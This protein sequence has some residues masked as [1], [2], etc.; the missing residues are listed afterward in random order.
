MGISAS[1]NVEQKTKSVIAQILTQAKHHP[2]K[3]ALI[4]ESLKEPP[5][6]VSY[7]QLAQKIFAYSDGLSE[8]VQK[9]D[10]VLLAFPSSIE[11]WLAFLAC[12]LLETIAVPIPL[13]T[14]KQ[15]LERYTSI[16]NDADA[17][18]LLTIDAYVETLQKNIATSE[19]SRPCE[20]LCIE[21][22]EV[23]HDNAY[24][25]SLFDENDIQRPSVIQYT[26]GSTSTPKGVIL[27]DNNILACAAGVSEI[28]DDGSL[29][30]D[31]KFLN[32]L[33]HYHDYGLMAIGLWPLI[34]G[35]TIVQVATFDIVRNCDKWYELISQY[36]INVTGITPSSF[37]FFKNNSINAG[38]NLSSL[39][40]LM[41]GAEVI[42]PTELAKFAEHLRRYQFES[43]SLTTGFGM[44]ET[45]VACTAC[46]SALNNTI[47]IERTDFRY[48]SVRLVNDNKKVDSVRF[49][50]NGRPYGTTKIAIVD[51]ETKNKANEL[52]LGEI[53][54]SGVAVA[55]G[56]WSKSNDSSRNESF[57]AYTATGD[58]PY[59]RSGDIGF[60]HDGEVFICGRTKE[61]INLNGQNL[62]PQDIEQFA[63]KVL[64]DGTDYGDVAAFSIEKN[65]PER[66]SQE[67]L[68]LVIGSKNNSSELVTHLERLSMKIG[69][70]YHSPIEDIVIIRSLFKTSSGKVQ[71]TKLKKAYLDNDLN[72]SNSLLEHN[73]MRSCQLEDV[74]DESNKF[75]LRIKA[76][77]S[78][79]LTSAPI[80][81]HDNFFVLG[82]DS[83]IAIQ[84]CQKIS[85]E[86]TIDLPIAEFF[87]HPTIAQLSLYLSNA[88]QPEMVIPQINN[89]FSPLSFSQERLWFIEQYE[90]LTY[91]YNNPILI[92]LKPSAH[93]DSISD[94]FNALLDKH[95]ILKSAFIQNEDGDYYQHIGHAP[96]NM[97]TIECQDDAHAQRTL[98]AEASKPFDLTQ[99]YPIRATLLKLGAHYQML[100]VIHHIASDG[101]SSSIFKDDF[102]DF[103]S[104]FA[105]GTEVK[106]P[107][108]EIQYKDYAHWQ[109]QFFT[110]QQLEKEQRY[111]KDKL[112]GCEA[113][114]LLTDFPRPARFDYRGDVYKF[115]IDSTIS[116]QLKSLAQ[117]QACTLQMLMMTGFYLMLNKYT[118]QT[119]LTIGTV[120]ANRP[121]SQLKDM[122][123]FFVNT[124]AMRVQFDEN[125]TLKQ[126]LKAVEQ[127]H[128]DAQ[129]HQS[130]PFEHLV[131]LLDVE[132][133]A[134]ANPLIQHLF[135]VQHFID[136][137]SSPHDDFTLEAVDDLLAISRL[138]LS[139]FVDDSQAAFKVKMEYATSLFTRQTIER[140][141]KHFN[142][143]LTALLTQ[144]DSPLSEVSLL[145]DA[146]YQQIIVDWNDT[147]APYP[148]DTSVGELFEQQVN[149]TPHQ[150][151][152]VSDEKSLTYQELNTRVNQLAHLIRREY[153]QKHGTELCADTPI[154]LYF[155]R[156]V[157]MVVSQLAVIKAGG[158]Y[159]PISPEYPKARTLAIV[160]DVT[161]E[162][163]ITQVHYQNKL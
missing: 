124:L 56:Y 89:P 132:R 50:S 48:G 133:E 102:T 91:A 97:A 73:R 129:R 135:V 117:E 95:T 158:A 5:V 11:F 84:L 86:F 100:I 75:V 32:W 154:A 103:Y 47:A 99:Y 131:S 98:Q 159:V 21:L 18:L 43:H 12:Q 87:S 163:V 126:L 80:T 85:H 123:G 23:Q 143:T 63:S 44:A 51:I 54:I 19:L 145:D 105:Y 142:H 53:W 36:K 35:Y 157:D 8:H 122:I 104:H 70:E 137:M 153:K 130:L 15:Q 71:R 147:D 93:L 146:E 111:W 121:Y 144:F 72:I 74:A 162:L 106:R 9:G 57:N 113:P 66:S 149:K 101:W 17:S 82:G 94:S 127:T 160:N 55:Q 83:L 119:D 115:E 125:G 4:Q 68:V 128:I 110:G 79:L 116:Q 16:I 41:I 34:L 161:T 28:H 13:L 108:L 62:F 59:L 141:A 46:F 77:W 112:A 69:A 109:R 39:K 118:Q 14:T 67:A 90:Q 10:R 33:P 114:Q 156:T 58:G 49:I 45:V 152:I 76:L 42:S 37:I 60:L 27:T 38:Y 138:D 78:E 22:S 25:Y 155:N 92:T 7:H 96:M 1:K 6:T 81:V 26:S 30:E 136:D 148:S 140:M 2:D 151:A 120:T 20:I 150:L 31:A 139:V 65:I 3:T 88:V 107:P 40:N 52:Q 64:H 61:V 134:S 29:A 24:Y